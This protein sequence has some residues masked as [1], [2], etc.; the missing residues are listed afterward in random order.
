MSW[1]A[2]HASCPDLGSSKDTIVGTCCLLPLFQE[3]AATVAMVRHSLDVI[4]KVVDLTNKGQTPVV[5]VDQPLFAIAKKIQWKWPQIYEEDKF[6]MFG[7][8]HI[9]LAALT[10]L[11]DL[12]KDSRWTSALVQAGVA[13]AGTADAFLKAAH[14]SCTWRA[15]QITASALHQ[16]I[17][18]AYLEYVTSMEAGIEPSSLKDWCKQNSQPMFKF[19]FTVLQLQLY[20]LIFVH[21]IRTGNFNLYVQSLTRLVP[22]FFSLHPFHF[23]YSL[24][25]SVH[26]R[27]MMTLSHLHSSIY[28]EFMKGHFT[29]QKTDSSFSNIAIDQAHEQHNCIVKDDGGAVGLNESPAAL[30]RWMVSRPEMASLIND[31]E[32]SIHHSKDTVDVHHHEQWPGVQK[33][34]LHDVKALKSAFDE[35]GN[36]FLESSSDRLVLDTKDITSEAVVDM[37]NKIEEMYLKQYKDFVNKCLIDRT[38]LLDDV[39]KKNV[40]CLFSML[41][42]R[43][44]T[45]TQAIVAEIKSDRNLFSRLY[46]A[47]QVRDSNLD[48]IFFV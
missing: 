16:S 36:P 27:D 2:F 18:E 11:G 19:W 6:V 48:E 14:I 35:Y 26:V 41:T 31:F 8:L 42:K 33:S 40:L 24:W 38:K 46:T 7:G 1:S 9:E 21:S 12:L 44:K 4:K 5:A 22:L 32:A 39:I 25:I 28:A 13:T 10:V 29:V 47:Y 3:D 43:Q 15:R 34:F 20:V 30:Q 45:N 17:K 37:V 23:N